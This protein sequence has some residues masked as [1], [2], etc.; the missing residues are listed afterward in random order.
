MPYADE[1]IG[2]YKLVNH[3]TGQCYVGQSQRVHKRIAD[4]FNLLRRKQ[5]PNPR[6]Q[7]SYNKHGAVS[8]TGEIE[9]VCSDTTE[10]DM[11]ENAFIS[12]E[13]WFDQ[14]VQFNVAEFAKAPMRGKTHT[15]EAKKKMSESQRK[16]TFDTANPEYRERLVTA[17]NKRF[18]SDP[19][20]IA[21]VKFLVENTHMSFAARGRAL[22]C[23][24]SSCRKNA[25]KLAHM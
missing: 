5:H 21:K 17:Q 12:G 23:D 3:V 14:P 22:G 20:F 7:N 15:A 13:A 18:F 24:T 1:V 11:I 10:L 4:H 16:R 19:K 8:F 6:L 25:L 9:V 2:I